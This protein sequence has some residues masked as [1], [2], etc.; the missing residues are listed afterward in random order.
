MVPV[1]VYVMVHT[2]YYQVVATCCLGWSG[3]QSGA[4]PG[5]G[6]KM[7]CGRWM[8]VQ[9]RGG[10]GGLLRLKNDTAEN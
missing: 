4:G 6:M 5:A 3:E 9:G 10:E 1:M 2:Y 7:S 8:D